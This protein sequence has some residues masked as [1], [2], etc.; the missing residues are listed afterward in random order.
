MA[1]EQASRQHNVI[2]VRD[3]SI[4]FPGVKA[5]QN[6]CTTFESGKVDAL[7]GANGAGKS[8]LMKIL[9]GANPGYT[10]TLLFNGE[11]VEVRAPQVAGELGIEIVYQEVDTALI[12]S[13]SVA[14]NIM[15][16]HMIYG[17][18][19]KTFLSWPYINDTARGVLERLGIDI[20]PRAMVST[21]TLAQK[22]MVVIARAVRSNCRFLILDEP[23]APL[24][25][26]ETDQLF[27]I[28]RQLKGNG[29]G[30]IFISHRLNELFEIC[31]R[32]TVLRDGRLIKTF[33][34]D[35]SVT[36]DDIVTLML[37]H[38]LV[39]EVD[40]SGRQ[41]GEDVLKVSGLADAGHRI[42]DIDL[43]LRRGEILGLAGLVGAGK[44]ELCKALFG[45]LGKTTGSI[46][47]NGSAVRFQDPSAAVRGGFALIPEERRQEGIVVGESVC[48]NL[49][50][51]TL[52]KHCRASFI[53]FAGELDAAKKK[54]ADLGIK[55]PSPAQ[56]VGLLSGG[57]QQKVTIGKW[58]DSDADIYIFDEPTKG[59][60][61]GAKAEI[62]DLIVNL[63]RQ[64]KSVIYATS[65]QSEI[66]MLTD[67]MY[68]MYS[69]TIQKEMTTEEADEEKILYYATGGSDRG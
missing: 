42:H 56:P 32:V 13:L 34:L 12:P 11:E 19:G 33:D 53:D 31:D 57:N 6:V 52:G 17:M 25:I 18:R 3:V 24:S 60:D 22:Q 37:G 43:H 23:T 5:L 14:E 26:S 8:T 10:G 45:A 48:T 58:L 29:V 28:V 38:A 20:D 62:Y 1:E 65:E 66:L 59:I 49:S 7:V 46:E 35:E 40:R 41:I 61:V 2:E 9:A 63:A 16:G 51:A 69:G 15:L 36:Q 4:E 55:T 67:R 39:N 54:I 50:L 68:V 30:V 44:T 64:G 21:L 47:V 27:D